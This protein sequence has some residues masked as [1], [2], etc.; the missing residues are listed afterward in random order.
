MWVRA[1]GCRLEGEP[2]VTQT[3]LCRLGREL[4][5]ASLL[6]PHSEFI[7]HVPHPTSLLFQP[8]SHAA[9][10]TMMA[11]MQMRISGSSLVSLLSFA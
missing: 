4:V 7:F 5:Q 6:H 2:L 8:Q 11:E 3:P 10:M 1:G 9:D